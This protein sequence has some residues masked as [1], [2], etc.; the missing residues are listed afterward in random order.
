MEKFRLCQMFVKL[1]TGSCYLLFV[2]HFHLEEG[3]HI[4]GGGHH[5]L[6][7]TTKVIR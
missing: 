7:K 1:W 6:L 4:K 2:K 5:I 3:L